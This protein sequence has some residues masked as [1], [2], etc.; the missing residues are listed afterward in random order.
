MSG[1][2]RITVLALSLATL[3]GP[4]DT[5]WA[6]AK[7]SAPA[8]GKGDT[9][10]T[11]EYIAD[12][13]KD[14]AQRAGATP[15]APSTPPPAA[16]DATPTVQL[17]VDDAIKL[18]LDR[19]LDI[20]VQRLNPSTY[21]YSYANLT[22]AY[23]PTLTSLL[24]RQSVT[25]PSTSTISGGSAAGA[26]VN[27][28]TNTYN[29]GIAQNI[30][31]GG[32]SFLAT[33]NNNKATT[34]STNSLFNP[35]F[36]ANWSAQY[37]QPLLRNFKIDNTRQQLVVTRLN[38][39][40]SEIQLQATIINTVSNVRNAY[41]DLVFAIQSV[42]VARRSVE[43]ADQ[44]VRDNQ[45]RVEI[46]T[47]APIDVVQAQSQAATQRQNL[48]VAEGTRRTNEI[49]LKRL[50]VAGTQDPNWNATINPTD[51]PEFAPQPIDLAGAVR[52]ALENRTDLQ[53]AKKNL[54]VND[55]TLKYLTN[56]TLPQA[57][58]VARYGL[59]GL[60]G[61][62][63]TG[64]TGNG[65]SR[66]CSGTIA[67]NYLDSL[68]TLF[69]QNYPTWT[70]QLNVN[71]PIGTSAQEATAARARVQVNQVAAQIKQIE[72]QIATDVTNAATNVQNNAERV[73][74][75][76]AAR[77]FAQRT[78]EA[79]Q[80]KFEVGMSTNYF[81]VQAQRDLATAQNNELQAVLAYRRSLVE[82]E[83]LQQTSLT[84]SNITILGR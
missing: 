66:V 47:M 57:D 7:P 50:I 64:C 20:A 26:G 53:Q 61:E 55:V 49:A 72:L 45:T 31:W 80:S 36:N 65:V 73:Q 8:T 69:K 59:V 23:R 79:E 5:A 32:G 63:F 1:M 38:Q 37:T 83:R 74:A 56:Q 11:D 62:Q 18:A 30:K 68:S 70:F 2:T 39:D 76:Q 46:G 34:T 6:Q 58:L 71:Y 25:N 9:R 28:A 33:L 19:N 24:S 29:G 40:I 75:A 82:L 14:A 3:V 43:L 67:G 21:D 22:A 52:R 44:L 4:A 16:A 41:W 27:T 13:I 15:G 12:L 54:S 17:S 35:S 51:R 78:L 42:E 60:G 77:E 81:V 10:I 84:T 48:A